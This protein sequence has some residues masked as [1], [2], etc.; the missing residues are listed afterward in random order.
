MKRAAALL[1]LLVPSQVEG[2][3]S[4]SVGAFLGSNGALEDGPAMVG[5]SL[6]PRWGVLG[7]RASGAMDQ[8]SSPVA[9]LLGGRRANTTAAWSGDLDLTLSPARWTPLARV[10][11]GFDPSLFAGVGLHGARSAPSA[12]D[13]AAASTVPSWSWGGGIRYSLFSWLALESEARWRTPFQDAGELP[14]GI[15]EGL[16]IR[17]GLTVEIGRSRRATDTRGARARAGGA[18]SSGSTPSSLDRGMGGVDARAPSARALAAAT[19]ETA[20]DYLGTPYVWGG[21]TPDQGFDC[22]GYVRWVYAMHG[23]QLPRVSREQSTVGAPLPLDLSAL[24][25]GDLM[26]FAG[27]G[28]RVDHIAIYAGNGRIIHSSRSGRGVRYDDLGSRRGRWYLDH[29]VEARRVIGSGPLL[30][31]TRGMRRMPLELLGEPL[32][33]GEAEPVD[34]APPPE[35]RN[36]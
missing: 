22:S 15:G 23:I 9:P 33:R 13:G 14:P 8:A 24:L 30:V 19:L 18:R 2:Q 28:S 34:A 25:P 29:W 32:F 11:G 4:M 10:F 7:V 1:L 31:D 35:S 6:E 5:M 36:R 27:D 17:G 20:E 3:S 12:P 21:N 16:E 26:A